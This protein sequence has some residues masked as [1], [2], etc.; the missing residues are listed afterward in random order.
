MSLERADSGG[1][2]STSIKAHMIVAASKRLGM[3]WNPAPAGN[4][5]RWYRHTDNLHILFQQIQSPKDTTSR[6]C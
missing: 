3:H 1:A 5:I 6:S 2:M 4:M